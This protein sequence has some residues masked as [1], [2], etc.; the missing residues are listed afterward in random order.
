MS[1]E[2]AAMDQVGRYW[3]AVAQGDGASGLPLDPALARTIQRIHGLGA[4]P[5]AEARERV[6]RSVLANAEAA[7]RQEEGSMLRALV[8]NGRALDAP[9]VG[10]PAA[11][12]S[13]RQRW[14]LTQLATAALIVL[15]LV[16]SFMVFGPGRVSRQEEPPV[17]IPAIEATPATPEAA[18]APVAE[19]LW[20]AEGSPEL[21]FREPNHPVVGPDG[22]IWLPD[23]WNSRIAIFAPDGTWLEDWGTEGSGDGEFLFE[24]GGIG[25]GG[26]AFDGDGNIYVAD[27]GNQR[28]QKF[29]P[30][31][32]FLSAWGSVGDGDGQFRQ[33][34][35]LAVDGQGLV[36]VSDRWGSIEVFDS[37]GRWLA[38]WDGLGSPVGITVDLDGNVWVAD[39]G[40]TEVI[41]FAPDGERLLTWDAFG[42]DAGEFSQPSGV[43]VDAEGRLFVSDRNNRVQIFS[44]DGGYLGSWGSF[45]LEPG[46][47]N[48]P[49]GIAVSDDGIAYTGEDFGRR[50]QAFR[51]L[52]PFGPEASI[53]DSAATPV[54]AATPA[55]GSSA[56]A[57]LVWE[58]RGGPGMPLSYPGYLALD[59]AGNLWIPDS[60]N[61]RYQIFSSNGQFFEAWGE[62]GSGE[63]Q[64]E[65]ERELFHSSSIAFAADG[66]F[67]VTDGGNFRVQKFGPDRAFV[68]AWGEQG[69][70]P[71]QFDQMNGIAVD[72]QGRV[73][74]TDDGRGDVQVFDADGAY[75]MT[76]GERGFNAGQFLF[77]TGSAVA[78]DAAGNV[79]VSDSSNQRIQT[80]SPDGE[81]LSL[82]AGGPREDELQR[83]NQLAIDGEGRIFVASPDL[84]QVQVFAADGTY[85][86][87]IGTANPTA[88]AEG[89]IPSGEF[90]VP[91]G[92][93]LDGDG[94][95]YV[96]DYEDYRVQKFRLAPP[97][98]P[99]A[100]LPGAAPAPA[101]TPVAEP[102]WQ[103]SGGPGLPL[104]SPFKPAIDPEGNLWVA[105]GRNNRFQIFSPDGEFLETWGTAGSGEGQFDFLLGGCACAAIVWDADG[106]FYV[107]DPG[108]Y[109]IQKFAPD[110]TF[111]TAWG[112]E[113]MADGQ[114]MGL[115]DLAVDASGRLFASDGGRDDIQ[116]FDRDGRLLDVW[117]ESGTEPGQ[118]RDPVGIALD[119]D[120]NLY[121][122]EYVENRIQKLSPQGAPL[123]EWGG[124]GREEGQFINP[125]EAISDAEGRVFVVDRSNRRV[126][127]FDG[128]GQFLASWGGMDER[129]AAVFAA[130]NG[131]ALDGE[132]NIYISDDGSDTVFK[133]RL[134]PPLA[135]EAA[136]NPAARESSEEA[137]G[138]EVVW[139]TSGDPELS[140]FDPVSMAFDPQ[141]N[142][143]VSDGGNSRFQIVSPEGE[144]LEAWGE[145]GT[146]PG[147][148]DFVDPS[149]FGGYGAGA[150]TFDGEGN[151]YVLD[152]ANYR[153]QKFAPDRAFLT[154]WGS[155]GEG[156]GQF[157]APTDIAIDGQG[158]VFVA[159]EGRNDVQVFDSDGRFLS[160][161]SEDREGWLPRP[162]SIVFDNDG[163]VWITHFTQNRVQKY[164]PAGAL[165]ATIGEY[166]TGPGQFR[167]PG[168]VAVDSQGRVFV[169]DWGA[170][171]I[172]VFDA[173][174]RFLAM[175]GELGLE[176]GQL[177]GPN[178]ALPDGAG[179]VYVAEDGNDRVQ[180]F[181][182]LPPLAPG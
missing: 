133:F 112:S 144:F 177:M 61:D 42:F 110:R 12:L 70:G 21:E 23:G 91:T 66:S 164:S 142:L 136:S 16:G 181:R 111:V 11:P 119:R 18:E 130:P 68:T 102:V 95:I 2:R 40:Q 161:W 107:A 170:A 154:T 90:L 55:A 97:L 17:F 128:V 24:N 118:F 165:L 7:R 114:F 54:V 129:G 43:D 109:R 52:P 1:D 160:A 49:Y 25:F 59:P 86:G 47:L 140:L 180:K 75:L 51:L 84:R 115:T 137:A 162:S 150:L 14:F 38:S 74:V 3:D 6:W 60:G 157:L 92:V 173:E 71:G 178:L 35:A 33:P 31:R 30:D 168:G 151:L 101:E 58:T 22:N 41:K 4:E 116:V 125:E 79:W 36:Y 50:L 175:W 155:Q 132:G 85:L 138:A 123:A 158:R 28:V 48:G 120:G 139:A 65:F 93:A 32:A 131:A 106:S 159:D 67:Y 172:Q 8:P 135:D 53:A 156:D 87:A 167:N 37:D 113:G 147:Y 105:D 103:T 80:F 26:V 149:L 182:L 174:G 152:S 81:F 117:G 78:I 100:E 82:L 46:K 83:P 77:T 153:V 63:G 69:S 15:T 27:S 19:F 145:E 134:L 98:A 45:G 9:I 94:N 10:M 163:N 88:W 143:W 148:F 89:E 96:A 13:G 76:I 126:Q 56:V 121:V 169:S 20:A 166:G 179:S 72:G 73:Y 39:E 57:E 124:F 104:D 127:V 176:E 29:G 146:A 108:N 99:A 5:S 141:G 171:T 34:V 122:S 62:T 44:P 64:F